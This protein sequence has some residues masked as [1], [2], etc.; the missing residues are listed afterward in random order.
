MIAQ[1]QGHDG[2]L[3]LDARV[4]AIKDAVKWQYHSA[5]LTTLKLRARAERFYV[6]KLLHLASVVLH[7][8]LFDHI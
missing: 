4:D 1:R 2:V 8:S 7:Q 6:R 3:R 5:P